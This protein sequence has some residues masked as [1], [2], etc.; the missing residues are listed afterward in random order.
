MR[1]GSIQGP[2]E[3][4][5]VLRAATAQAL[6]MGAT[7]MLRPLRD[8]LAAGGGQARLPW[9]FTASF[10]GVVIAAPLIAHAA[11]RLGR[12][13]L[14]GVIYGVSALVLVALWIGLQ[15]PARGRFAELFFVWISVFNL[16][17][18]SLLWSVLV[19]R[20]GPGA[21]S[22]LFGLIAIGASAGAILGPAIAAAVATTLGA[23]ALL[24]IA[25]GCL[26]LLVPVLG[27]L[28]RGGDG[29]EALGGSAFDG[30]RQLARSPRLLRIAAYVALMSGTATV[31]YFEQEAIV[32]ARF[33]DDDARTA[34][35]A[36]VELAVNALAL[37]L[38]GLCTGPWLT[39]LGLRSALVLL[40][41]VSA[42]GLGL[43]GAAPAWWALVVAQVSRRTAD[44]ALAR[45]AREVL[46][47]AVDRSARYKAKGIIDTVVY[48][49]GDALVGWGFLALSGLGLG[50]GGIAWAA[51]PLV[52]LWGLVGWHLGGPTRG[53]GGATRGE[54][55]PEEG[56]DGAS[57]GP[58]EPR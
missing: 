5:L 43:V 8:A 48:R 55:A 35:L 25:A 49:G 21:A 34:A 50:L 7:T 10:L 27:P 29:G 33:V 39:R 57:P 54:G 22:R 40:P 30:I 26:A 9:L 36:G 56:D 16:V 2:G 46:F 19:D 6:V 37:L 47:T 11:A 13:R 1:R 14:V 52:A 24:L 15:G 18:V 58:S 44:Y 12:A 17:T 45:P 31:L 41:L 42:A 53:E 3:R 32:A 38:Q 4:S 20:L 51:L 28:L 23:D